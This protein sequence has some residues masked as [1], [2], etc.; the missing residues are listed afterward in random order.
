VSVGRRRAASGG[1]RRAGGRDL[2]LKI[3]KKDI[4]MIFLK[5]RHQDHFSSSFSAAVYASVR[6]W[7]TA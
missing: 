1:R 4:R 7:R 5:K 6:G 2:N 3:K